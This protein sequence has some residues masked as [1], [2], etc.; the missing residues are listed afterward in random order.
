[1]VEA[2]LTQKTLEGTETGRGHF[3]ETQDIFGKQKKVELM[4]SWFIESFDT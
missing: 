1:M 3:L 4:A 2:V